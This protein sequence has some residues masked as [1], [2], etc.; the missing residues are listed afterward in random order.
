M[1][2]LLSSGIELML[3]GM[4][5]VYAFLAMLVIAIKIMSSG[6][7]RFF[8]DLPSGPV[9]FQQGEDPGIIAAI[10]A[11]VQQYRTKHPKQ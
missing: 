11:A 7:K 3:I 8:P 5:M 6:I 2:E 1:N 10:A 4:G 9:V